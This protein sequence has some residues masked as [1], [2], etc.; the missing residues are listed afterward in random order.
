MKK[1]VPVSGQ[2]VSFEILF[3]LVSITKNRRGIFHG[4]QKRSSVVH[5][6]DLNLFEG[7][8]I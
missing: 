4:K 3:R 7:G 5:V 2:N 8:R 1:S 6:Y